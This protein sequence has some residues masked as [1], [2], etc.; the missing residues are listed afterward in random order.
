MSPERVA[1]E[2]ND[3]SVSPEEAARKFKPTIGFYL[4]MT[5]LAVLTFVVA[6]DATALAVALPVSS[7]Q[8]KKYPE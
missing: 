8:P 5:T 2:A 7:L 4:A 3:A 6:I 1:E